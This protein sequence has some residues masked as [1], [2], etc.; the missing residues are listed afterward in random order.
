MAKIDDAAELKPQVQEQLN[1][2]L[3]TYLRN[4]GFLDEKGKLKSDGNEEFRHQYRTR[5]DTTPKGKEA[6]SENLKTEEHTKRK[7]TRTFWRK[8]KDTLSEKRAY[9]HVRRD[10]QAKIQ[11]QLQKVSEEQEREAIRQKISKAIGEKYTGPIDLNA[12]TLA[13][14]KR[15]TEVLAKFYS[16]VAAARLNADAHLAGMS[17]N[18]LY[19]LWNF[20]A[21]A[22]IL[23]NPDTRGT[24]EFKPP[25]FNKD[26]TLKEGPAIIMH[27][28]NAANTSTV[29]HE[30]AHIFLKDYQ[31]LIAT[32]PDLPAQVREDW[33]NLTKWLGI[34][35]IDPKSTASTRTYE[36]NERWK[37]AHEKFASAFEQY[38]MTGE[39][40]TSWL[41]RAFSRF[42]EWISHV[43]DNIKDIKYTGQDGQ[44]HEIEISPNIKAIFDRML[45]DNVPFVPSA[46]GKEAM[47]ARTGLAGQSEDY[48]GQSR[49][50]RSDLQGESESY[51]QPLNNDVDLDNQVNVVKIAETMPNVPFYQRIKAFNKTMQNEII[52]R[53]ADGQVVN[54]HTGLTITLS[55]NG[56]NHI[57]DTARANDNIAGEV[58]FQSVPSLDILAREAYRVETHQDRK[59]SATK[60]EGQLGNLKQV[61]RFLVPVEFNGDTHIL[62][63]TAKEYE[64]GKAEI[65]EVSLYDMKYA[66]KLSSH[67]SQNSPNL[68]G[69]AT[70]TLGSP[71][72]VSVRDMIKD[73]NDAEGNPY[74]SEDNS[75]TYNQFIYQDAAKRLDEAE[76]STLRTDSLKIAKRLARKG[77]PDKNI[78]LATGWTQ[79]AQGQW[80]YE[81]PDGKVIALPTQKTEQL[82]AN[83][84]TQQEVH[85]LFAEIG[86]DDIPETLPE[87]NFDATDTVELSKVFNAPELFKAYPQLKTLEFIRAALPDG[88]YGQY[89]M[90]TLIVN[91]KLNRNQARSVIIYQL[92]RAIQDIEGGVLS[93]NLILTDERN[94]VKN[95]PS[96]LGFY[97]LHLYKNASPELRKKF[98]ELE[99]K[100]KQLS[101]N[102]F[103]ELVRNSLRKPERKLFQKLLNV[104][105]MMR[106][107]ARNKYSQDGTKFIEFIK[108]SDEAEALNAQQRRDWDISK[109]RVNPPDM[110]SLRK[111]NT[112]GHGDI[113][114][115]SD[116]EIYNQAY[117]FD[118]A[119]LYG[120]GYGEE[121]DEDND[122]ETDDEGFTPEG[123]AQFEEVRKKYQGTEQWMKAPNGKKT[124]LT[125]KQ[126]LQVRTLNFKKFFGD[127]ENDPEHASKVVDENG[128]PLVVW[129]GTPKGGFSVF[130]T[131]GEGMSANTGAWFTSRREN[132]QSYQEYSDGESLYPVFLNIRNPYVIEGNERNWNELGDIR[133]VDEETWEDFYEKD[134]GEP[135]SS[136]QDAEDYIFSKVDDGT[137]E[138]DE[139]ARPY[140]SGDPYQTGGLLFGRYRVEL[141]EEFSHTN[142]IVRGV[143]NHD[144]TDDDFDGVIFKNIYDTGPYMSG[145]LLSDVFV[146][147]NSNA[148]KSATGN[149]GNF[150]NFDEN[151]Y[152][153]IIGVNGALRLDEAEGVTTRMDNLKIAKR[154]KKKLA[155]DWQIVPVDNSNRWWNTKSASRDIW[156]ATGWFRG[157]DAQWKYE[158]PYGDFIPKKLKQ[159][160]KGNIKDAKLSEIFNAPQL[161]K[162]YPN[163]K[164]ILVKFEDLH[165]KARGM[166]NED[167]S[168]S[169]DVSGTGF[170]EILRSVLI[171]ELQHYIQGVEGFAAGGNEETGRYLKD[172]KAV[173]KHDNSFLNP[174]Y[175]AGKNFT[176][177]ANVIFENLSPKQQDNF[178]FLREAQ[179]NLSQ[180]EFNKLLRETLTSG[181]RKKFDTWSWFIE[182]A[183]RHSKAA[184]MGIYYMPGDE[185]YQYIAG[186]VE[187]RNAARRATKYSPSERMYNAPNRTQDVED[188]KQFV[189][190][191]N[192]RAFDKTLRKD[193]FMG[194]RQLEKFYQLVT[195]ATGNIIWGNQFDLA[196][197]GSGEG[198]SDFGHGAYFSQNPEIVEKFRNSGKNKQ[199]N[200][201]RNE[202]IDRINNNL[203]NGVKLNEALDDIRKD[204]KLKIKDL[205]RE[206]KA[207]FNEFSQDDNSPVRRSKSTLKSKLIKAVKQLNALQ[208]GLNLINGISTLEDF[209]KLQ[210][211]NGN[212]YTFDIPEDSELLDWDLPLFQQ[213]RQ[214]QEKLKDMLNALA[215]MGFSGGNIYKKAFFSD[216]GGIDIT[217]GRAGNIT[218]GMLYQNIMDFM[219]QEILKTLSPEQAREAFINHDKNI[220]PEAKIRTSQIFNE[221]GIPGHKFLDKSKTGSHNYVIWNTDKTKMTGIDPSSNQDAIDYFNKYK[222][223]HSDGFIN[224]EAAEK[225]NQSAIYV[226]RDVLLGDKFAIPTDSFTG[227]LSTGY[228]AGHLGYGIHFES[229]LDAAKKRRSSVLT[230]DDKFGNIRFS[231]HDGRFYS[232]NQLSEISD[233]ALHDVLADASGYILKAPNTKWD[234]VK[235][236]LHN[237]YSKGL[238]HYED[239]LKLKGKKPSASDRKMLKSFKQKIDVLDEINGF[240]IVG[241]KNGNLY[242]FDIPENY[243]LLVWNLPLSQ[244]SKRVQQRVKLLIN[245]F[246]RRGYAIEEQLTSRPENIFLDGIDKNSAP[247]GEITGGM[248]YQN[249]VSVV[250]DLMKK[251][252]KQKDGI[253][254]ALVRASR[255]FNSAGIPGHYY[256]AEGNNY[257][258][259]W[260]LEKIKM[261]GIDSSSDSE[262][263]DAFNNGGR[264]PESENYNQQVLEADEQHLTPEA[265]AQMENIRKRYQGTN[266]WLKAPNGKKSNLSERQWLQVRTPNFINWFGDW[267]NDP[268]HASKVVDENGEPLIVYHGSRNFGFSTFNTENGA[269]F[270]DSRDTSDTYDTSGSYSVF[271]NI[272]NP[273]IVDYEGKGSLNDGNEAPSY[274]L[275]NSRSHDGVICLNIKDRGDY[276]GG[277]AEQDENGNYTEFDEDTVYGVKNPE[278]IK[279]ATANNGNFDTNDA[280]IYHQI[281]VKRK[282]EMDAA[283]SRRRPDLT[284]EQRKFAIDEIE[285]LGESV[286]NGG[287]PKV[288]KIAIKWLLDGHIILPEDNYKILDAIKICEQQH[289]DPMHFDDPNVILAQ[290]TIKE[291][292][293]SRRINPDTVP[294]FSHKVEYPNGI[295]VYTVDNSRDGQAV[296]RKIIDTHWG[297]DANPWC[298]AARTD[299]DEYELSKAWNYWNNYDTVDKRIAF[300]NGKL[301]AFCASDDETNTWW[302]REDEPHSDKIPYT[303][304]QN[305]IT[306][307]Y[308]YDEET[309]KSSKTTEK[310]SDGTIREWYEDG[311]LATEE[312]PDGTEHSWYENGQLR[313][314]KLPDGTIHLWH[315]NG[316]RQGEILPDRTI[317]EWYES[318]QLKKEDLPDGTRREWYED[319]KQKY[320]MLPDGTNRTWYESGQ[321]EFEYLPD[322]TTREWF[323]DGT[324][325]HEFLPDR[326]EHQWFENGQLQYEVLPDKTIHEWY[327]DGKQKYE[328][329][330]DGTTRKWYK[331]GKLESEK[332]PDGTNRLWLEDRKKKLEELPN[333]TKREWYDNGNKKYEHLPG[334]STRKWYEN[335]QI[336]SERL[337]DKTF[338]EWYPNG[339]IQS[340]KLPDGTSR[341]WYE[342]GQLEKEILPGHEWRGWYKNGQLEYE[343]LPDRS[344]REWDENGQLQFERL[345][346]GEERYYQT[347]NNYDQEAVDYFNKYKQ[348]HPDG[349][350]TSDAIERFEQLVTH[351]TGNIIL[352]NKFDLRYVGTGEG[353][354]VY[355]H[356]FYFEQNPDVA[357]TYRKMGL[358]NEG[359]GSISIRL[360]DGRTFITPR[361]KSSELNP[362]AALSNV[363]ND[364]WRIIRSSEFTNIPLQQLKEN[365]LR[366]YHDE[367]NKANEALQNVHDEPDTPIQQDSSKP[368][369]RFALSPETLRNNLS[370]RIKNIREKINALDLISDYEIHKPRNG[371][372][373]DV[374]IP[375]DYELL[376]WDADLSH[377]PEIVRKALPKIRAELRRLGVNMNKFNRAK[378]G[379]DL[380]RAIS[381]A[382]DEYLMQNTPRDGIDDADERT[383]ALLNKFGIPGHRYLDAGSRAKGEGYHNF[384]IWNTDKINIVGIHQDSDTEAIDYFNRTKQQQENGF[385]N[386]AMLETFNQD[387]YTGTGN[388]ILGNKFDMRYKGSNEGNATFGHGAYLAQNKKVAEHY[389]R[390][391]L[392]PDT[393]GQLTITTIN[394]DIFK[395]Q[396]QGQWDNAANSIILNVLNDFDSLLHNSKGTPSL[397]SIKKDMAK[398]YK[399]ELREQ[400]RIIA[401]LKHERRNF[402]KK[403]PEYSSFNDDIE[404]R[405]Q[406]IN[407]IEKKIELMNSF[408]AFS[409]DKRKGNIYKF[410]VPEDEDLL[411]LDA[412]LNKQ[413]EKIMPAIQKAIEFLSEKGYGIL[414][415]YHTGEIL[416]SYLEDA[417]GSDEAA[418]D[419]LNNLGIPG[420][421]YWDG[422][423]RK[424]GEGT[425]NFVIWNM[426]KL[427]MLAVEGDKEAEEYFRKIQQA[428][429]QNENSNSESY[430]QQVL[431]AGDEILSPEGRAQMEEVRRQYEGSE[432]WLMAPNGKKSNLSERQWLQVR[433][434]NFINW[435]GDWENN[436]AEASKVLDENG[437]PL[438]VYHGSEKGGFSIF[439]TKGKNNSKGA[440]TYFSSNQDVA[441]TFITGKISDEKLYPVF[442]NIRNPYVLTDKNFWSTLEEVHVFDNFRA[443]NIFSKKDGTNFTSYDDAQEYI[444]SVLHDP[445]NKRYSVEARSPLTTDELAR[446]VWRQFR[447]KFDGV[448]I[449]NVY[450]IGYPTSKPI[451]TIGDDFII[452]KPNQIKSATK[453]NGNF[454]PSDNE[455]YQ[456]IIGEQGARRLDE[457]EGVTFRMDNLNI[458]KQMEKK[459]LSPK[460]IWL[461]TGWERG[462]EGKWRYE[463]HDGNIILD[464][465][466]NLVNEGDKWGGISDTRLHNVFEAQELFNAYPILKNSV[467][468]LDER[469]DS[470]ASYRKSISEN[471]IIFFVRFDI[472]KQNLNKSKLAL[473]HEIQHSIQDIEGFPSGSYTTEEADALKKHFDSLI[474]NAGEEYQRGLRA[475][476]YALFSKNINLAKKVVASAPK[477]IRPITTEM[478]KTFNKYTKAMEPYTN[479]AGEVE[480]RNVQ[481]RSLMTQEQRR[482]TTPHETEDVPRKRQKLAQN[483]NSNSESY[484][485]VI[486]ENGAR[487]LDAAGSETSRM[488]NLKIA[489][490]MKRSGKDDKTIRLATGWELGHEGKWKYEIP[491]G[492]FSTDFINGERLNFSTSKHYKLGEIFDAQELFKAY[493]ELKNYRVLFN[494]FDNGTFFE[495]EDKTFNIEHGMTPE[496][497]RSALVHEIQHAIQ[498]IEGFGLG[499]GMHTYDRFSEG[500]GRIKAG[501]LTWRNWDRKAQSIWRSLTPSQ[502]GLW[503]YLVGR[504]NNEFDGDYRFA[505]DIKADILSKYLDDKQQDLF[506]TWNEAR[507]N[508]RE[509]RSFGEPVISSRDAYWRSAGEVE[510]RNVQSRLNMPDEERRNSLLAETE[511][512]KPQEEQ[513]IRRFDDKGREVFGSNSESFLAPQQLERFNQLMYHGS[514]NILLGNRFNL[515]YLS[516]G[517]GGQ[518]FGYG[519]Y[520]AQAKDTSEYYRTAGMSELEQ[521]DTAFIMQDGKEIAPNNLANLLFRTKEKFPQKLERAFNPH[522]L[523]SALQ[524]LAHG[525]NSQLYSSVDEV[526]DFV[527][528][529]MIDSETKD[530]KYGVRGT[531]FKVFMQNQGEKIFRDTIQPLLPV[532]V[533]AK[534]PQKGNLYSFDGP[535]DFELL[536]WNAH[537]SEQP[538]QVR[539]ALERGGL[540][541]D[542][543][544]T[545]EQLY[546]RLQK[547]FG[548]GKNG[549]LL[550]SQKLNE[551]GI[552]GHRFWDR[553][554]RDAKSGTHNFVIWNT[555]TLRLLGLSEDSDID[556]QDYFRAENLYQDELDS[557]DNDSD[558][559]DYTN[560]DYEQEMSRIDEF[561]RASLDAQDDDGFSEIYHQPAN[562]AQ[563]PLVERFEQAHTFDNPETERAFSDALKPEDNSSSLIKNLGAVFHGFKGD[564]PELAGKNEFIFARE[565]LRKL[566]R[567][568]DAKT[569]LA[570]QSL[571]KSLHNL[572]LEQFNTFTRLLLINDLY[573]FKRYNAGANLPLGFNPESLKLE[574][575]KFSRLAQNDSNILQAIKAEQTVHEVIR[576]EL[577]QLANELGM[578]KFAEKVKCYDFY[579]LD[580]TRVI[581]GGNVNADYISAMGDFR[582]KQ[583]QDIERLKALKD[584]L[585]RYDIKKKLQEKFGTQWGLHIPEGYRTF[586][587]LAGQFVHSAHTLT[588]NILDMA[589]EQSG[590]DLGLD[591]KAVK[592]FK[593]KLSDNSGEQLL[594]LPNEIADSLEGLSKHNETGPIMKIL[595]AITSGWKK[596]VLFFPTRAFKYNLR[597]LTGDADALIAGNPQA[598]KFTGRA[599]KDLWA[600]YYGNGEIS[601]ELKKFQELGG[602]ITIENTQ[603]LGDYKKLKEFQH[604]MSELEGKSA[605]AWKKLPASAW[606]IID[607]FAWS[608]IQKVTDW[609]E[610]ILRYACYLSYLEQMQK[611]NGLPNNWGASVKDEVMSLPDIRDRAFKMANELL[612][613]YDQ[614]SETGKSIREFTVPFYSWLEVNAKRYYQLL[615]NGLFDDAPG[616]FVARFLKGQLMN[617]P[618][619]AWKLGKTYF[620]VNLFTMLIAAFNHLVWPDDE[621]KLP[622]DVQ[623]RPHITLGHDT[624]GRVLYFERVGALLDNLEWFGQ[625]NSPL[626]PFAKD[627]KDILDGK[628][629]FTDFVGKLI[630]SPINKAINAINPIIKT[631]AELA[632]GKSIYPDFTNPRNIGDA[633]KYIAQS[634][635]LSWPYKIIIDEPRS[636]WLEF[637]NLFTYSAD[638]DEAAYFYTIGLVRQFRENV[639]GKKFNSFSSTRRGEVLR[640]LK[641]SL[642]L[643]DNE[644]V[645]RYLKEY[646]S[647]GGDN[648]GLKASMRNM[649]PL[650]GLNKKEQEQF[651]RWLSQDDRKYLN[652]ANKYFHQLADRF[653]R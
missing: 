417:L 449:K 243:E 64:T 350:I 45:S 77:N 117:H 118:D 376:D 85:D 249:V 359:R 536:D 605:P 156:L 578:K 306:Y 470:L 505:D 540:I 512:I 650:S 550:A 494:D 563:N 624:N 456:Q 59:P 579:I 450:D 341:E 180:D 636:D 633:G 151:I 465:W 407:T 612:G 585:E 518:A 545:G 95:L 399:Q 63:L 80:L 100:A 304:K 103:D 217:Q 464:K 619:Y 594:V 394:G 395:S 326:T 484:N 265:R 535:D 104:S 486:G 130:D 282:N 162:A 621:D 47:M 497:S 454:S 28:T 506:I 517:E 459:G 419:Y 620:F 120:Y 112:N 266:Q 361:Y 533:R 344:R 613:A 273:R 467:I 260:N 524:N 442:L 269:W 429:T 242:K 342:N 222:Q 366:Q 21:V 528:N 248:L 142:D 295:T 254:D 235:S 194:E 554:S 381:S 499:A 72:M 542:D 423:S 24:T 561:S 360:S 567:K 576:D 204:T 7:D 410:D 4:G 443:R 460:K 169:I 271:L 530:E 281:G 413:S 551:L 140:E 451:D 107:L 127:W 649:N 480:A 343:N 84:L 527:I 154:L 339:Q 23:D 262:A 221:F 632:T 90:G 377:Q 11:E 400:K 572:S 534:T 285:K 56:L 526:V 466:T 108:L 439:N 287:N 209:K 317:R 515:K 356:G 310:L 471:K 166:L 322:G 319:G 258:V 379:E 617:T 577:S 82:P 116:I 98:V 168:I 648:K 33:L 70:G 314:E 78:W 171:H 211:K 393:R 246:V 455:I 320:E 538:E 412:K 279:S 185:A 558:V 195:H 301:T 447:R 241:Q 573:T 131:T 6:H 608:G 245:E 58:I 437:E 598:L 3:R 141:D 513:I 514:K 68:I 46:E 19:K 149:N 170:G 61:H 229:S 238:A 629:T 40:P 124:N 548:G 41:K 203:N 352:G 564:F 625:E 182:R 208:S 143:F 473:L 232:H 234:D 158:I 604:L 637:K 231:L 529:K 508:A 187:A 42:K 404:H 401:E 136:R 123:R 198:F 589:I 560:G 483:G 312:L 29:L 256:Q 88:V 614:V 349:F 559:I 340:E 521:S 178:I 145:E 406:I 431:G 334:K 261:T 218:G 220:I 274:W 213:P 167:G 270:S 452:P 643:G 474:N 121:T 283:L 391:G 230:K 425:H 525:K 327:E 504:V 297:E 244:Q 337:A 227:Y 133:I 592:E 172:K 495:W 599:I 635:G 411:N 458:A 510:A 96:A 591:D 332:L 435:F 647:L 461:A 146:T 27:L 247:N 475:L 570:V 276:L 76:H 105:G 34:S 477:N 584:I 600:A 348:E 388:I 237:Y 369:S 482:T 155:P 97:M 610:Q 354:R 586:N 15:H 489:Q 14:I 89:E 328:A 588:E 403:T 62:K 321:L 250:Y 150:S 57:L 432:K 580:Y 278:Q 651:L 188:D 16:Q 134:N 280:E 201:F 114:V 81:I 330:P 288:E 568:S 286:R 52:G 575:E 539:N 646:Y 485:Q 583:L 490:N 433:T 184:D 36:E 300:Y 378:N 225:F 626:F 205:Q 638:A 385:I 516:T 106:K 414:P 212:L 462:T 206:I 138:V 644:R 175:F 387:A 93:D 313:E 272:R 160:K 380:Y 186:E 372:V 329:L 122:I 32:I 537:V 546:R 35:D 298:L 503:R 373:Y 115:N 347:A 367:L 645:Q 39:A 362:D 590:R 267:E 611:N 239:I 574:R 500:Y 438:V 181:F 289:L 358:P 263:I 290:Y 622:P 581:K 177:Q 303:F 183:E 338:R 268:E 113:Q 224:P 353:N 582:T 420:H 20:K 22:D 531:S 434:P 311:Q 275:E 453:N 555:D 479:E 299:E 509:S 653:L 17:I 219:K 444:K 294:E 640:K 493:P 544:E 601:P 101:K 191:D 207:L 345:A 390:Y 523:T 491:D 200:Q 99:K 92:Q 375:E 49:N 597:N 259:I 152:H 336:K 593:R 139:D 228:L 609:R 215:Q 137:F 53:F 164:D 552:P 502:K 472:A 132:A 240:E 38:Y 562:I 214:V 476:A 179:K 488:D 607:K 50:S 135:F 346:D 257:Y 129:H 371:N 468:V 384:V 446:F 236:R 325:K 478:L 210:K 226:T 398:S 18:E 197:V 173:N 335:G 55:K 556:A 603:E 86:I 44:Q 48:F 31:D 422:E 316:N 73:V 408:S 176:R 566:G 522:S 627:I 630:S 606:K 128:E 157:I 125:E 365:L 233:K 196:Y 547:Q 501:K 436:P 364:L 202:I 251:L 87:Y 549:E 119:F 469:L 144:L 165:E 223:E 492:N 25:V 216:L 430:I 83:V 370:E 541:L 91:S 331:D 427:K 618:Y 402:D 571:E 386:S 424:V 389:R 405:Q 363:L 323:K 159:I 511:D 596:A 652:R 147:P 69:R 109:R 396:G 293:A 12:E 190:D 642:R 189:F 305:G 277:Y 357:E 565:V 51:N 418:S 553:M 60:I 595:K 8:I 252:P 426:D 351:A 102:E 66:K 111:K 634:L 309:G 65:D 428:Q 498:H 615:K 507:L 318:E 602:A 569:Q 496:K 302:D 37:N 392:S 255:L 307:E 457:A 148:I 368:K 192:R 30:F 587:P 308:I 324:Q 440:G 383:S 519:A 54:E 71:D 628:Q 487:N 199:V 110:F 163:I 153:Q 1:K 520:L 448:I 126:W 291:T 623:A 284:P 67:P 253:N 43:Y 292:K 409:L 639:L 397:E 616:D 641:T 481:T 174:D 532:E 557:L 10:I 631:P 374:D 13:R 441:R 445:N 421:Y 296:V 2:N 193:G 382:M 74:F 161:F 543:N 355:G 26:G 5:A 9:K 416:Y 94:G 315:E 264:K 415:K 463:I 333:G 75:E 79:N